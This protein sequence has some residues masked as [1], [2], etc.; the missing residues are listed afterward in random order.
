MF[1]KIK[2]KSEN[3][4]KVIFSSKSNS[5]TIISSDLTVQGD[6]VSEGEIQIDGK[7]NGD[8]RCRILIVG[9]NAQIK[10][11]IQADIAKV[12]GSI[13][14]LLF[15][16]TVFLSTTAKV[17]GDITHEK[18]EIEQGAYLEGH[19]CHVDDPIPAEQGPTDLMLTDERQKK[20]K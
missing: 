7:I 19:C 12:Y 17:V 2:N 8:I 9:A 13:D 15:A 1:L 3:D 14:G 11:S 10:G 4:S 16:K 18:I 6:L 5:P 20:E